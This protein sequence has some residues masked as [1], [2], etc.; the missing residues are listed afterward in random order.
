[1]ADPAVCIAWA[2]NNE[3]FKN[4]HDI[5]PDLPGN[6]VI[7]NGVKTWNGAHAISGINSAAFPKQFAAIAAIPQDQ[8]GPAVN[9]F[10]QTEEWSTWFAQIISNDLAKRAFDWAVNGGSGTSA[11]T[12]Q[13]AIDASGGHVT[14]DHG[15]GPITVAAANAIDPA[16]LVPAFQQARVAHLKEHDANNPDLAGLIARALK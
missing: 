7:V 4:L 13:T 5:V 10:Y 16:V 2:L 11:G 12:L 8:R 9:N 15:W 14:V 1:M 6:W 3:D